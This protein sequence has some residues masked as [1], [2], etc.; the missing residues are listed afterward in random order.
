[1]IDI[2]ADEGLLNSDNRY[3]IGEEQTVSVSDSGSN[4]KASLVLETTGSMP[5]SGN[6]MAPIPS[7]VSYCLQPEMLGR[8]SLNLTL[9][10]R[11]VPTSAGVDYPQRTQQ[12]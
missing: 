3:I 12:P 8:L 6:L 9:K 11:N 4:R 1:M 2:V 7:T 10:A 5:Q